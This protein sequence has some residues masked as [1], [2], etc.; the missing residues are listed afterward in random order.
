MVVGITG[1]IGSGKSTV[2]KLFKGLGSI[3]TYI[4]DEEAKKLMNSSKV[5]QE[6]LVLEF[7]EE[8]YLDNKL[9]RPFLANIVF[10][11]KEKLATLNAIVHPVVYNHLESFIKNNTDKDYILYENAILFE[12]GSDV[13]CDKIITVTAPE[14]VKIDRV[15]SRDKTSEKEVRN[16][17]KNQWKDS[18]KTLQSNY[19][20]CN[21]SLT[22]TKEQVLKIHNKLTQNLL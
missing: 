22:K 9:N 3:A 15:I 4:A 5:I 16:R 10:K 14:K 2:L 11:N 19:I 8:V 7:G 17:M 13:F 18:K 21:V 12:N 6:K 20:I 1:G